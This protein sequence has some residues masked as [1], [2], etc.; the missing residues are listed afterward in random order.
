LYGDIVS[1]LL[2][3]SAY[4]MSVM[5]G[6]VSVY[7]H[8]QTRKRG[9]MYIGISFLLQGAYGF[10]P[11]Q[12]ITNFLTNTFGM[13]EQGGSPLLGSLIIINTTAYAIIAA[14]ALVGILILREEFK[15][16]STK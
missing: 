8:F 14:I 16:K 9:F 1:G 10:V 5:V 15:P 13:T 3:I 2:Q 12:I 11:N 4:V 6:I 7:L